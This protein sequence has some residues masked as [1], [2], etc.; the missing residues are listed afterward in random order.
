MS[1]L[2]WRHGRVRADSAGPRTRADALGDR[3]AWQATGRPQDRL[4]SGQRTLRRL[5][6]QNAGAGRDDHLGAQ[7][8]GEGGRGQGDVPICITVDAKL[9]PRGRVVISIWAG[10]FR[11]GLGSFPHVSEGMIEGLGPREPINAADLPRLASMIRTAT[12][13][14]VVLHQRAASL[15]RARP[16]PVRE[17]CGYPTNVIAHSSGSPFTTTSIVSPTRRPSTALPT[18]DD[19]VTT[20]R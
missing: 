9:R 15:V 3:G 14:A 2:P 13:V 8:C 19:G 11:G 1:Q 6:R 18:G 20:D 16:R 4:P 5:A 17:R 7:R 12:G 10:S